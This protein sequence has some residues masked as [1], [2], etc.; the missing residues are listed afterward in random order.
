MQLW[1]DENNERV[2]QVTNNSK[3]GVCNIKGEKRETKDRGEK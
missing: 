2:N 1:C 3:E